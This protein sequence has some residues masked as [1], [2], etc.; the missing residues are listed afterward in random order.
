MTVNELTEFLLP[1]PSDPLQLGALLTI[2]ALLFYTIIM[3]HRAARPASWEKKWNGGTPDD[4]EDDLDIEHGSVTDLWHAVATSHEKLAEIM[5]GLLLVVGLLGTFIGL[6]MALN[7]ASHL[8]GQSEVITSNSMDDLMQLLNN[9]G[10]KFKTSTWGIA[11]FI[12]LKAW[13]EVTR[14]DEKRLTWVIGKVKIEI[15][16]RKNERLSAENKK[17]EL[18]FTQLSNFSGEI[19]RAIGSLEKKFDNDSDSSKRQELTN[20]L[21]RDICVASTKTGNQMTAFTTGTQDI[22]QQ[23]A[24]AATMMAS[25]STL[26]SAAADDLKKVVNEF[27]E[28]FKQVL[29]DVRVDLGSA[30]GNMSKEAAE[31]L[32]SGSAEL[33]KATGDISLALKTLSSSVQGTLEQVKTS[34]TESLRI[35]QIIQKEF[36]T[37]SATVMEGIERSTLSQE[38]TR[39]SIS[40][41]LESVADTRQ[42]MT[43]IA[44]SLQ[45]IAPDIVDK[46]QAIASLTPPLEAGINKVTETIDSAIRRQ[47]ATD[48]I[49]SNGLNSATFYQKQLVESMK[50]LQDSLKIIKSD[51]ETSESCDISI[52]TSP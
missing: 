12:I 34:T 52:S 48:E 25:G 40:S 6:G 7:N 32:K 41:G 47:K 36:L 19:T 31:T 5:P 51:R 17:I 49:I 30:I 4:K 28:E 16:S 50:D 22:V 33:S 45:K 8:L 42:Q 23:M 11:G 43:H 14:F 44:N 13:S 15:E 29:T 35:Q 10:N 24:D 20:A 38:K 18:L 46:L 37:Q 39:K 2:S 26:V 21:L 3:T 27:S 1:E 9:L